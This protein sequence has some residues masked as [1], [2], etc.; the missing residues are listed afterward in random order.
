MQGLAGTI[1]LWRKS[2]WIH[3]RLYSFWCP[4]SQRQLLFFQIT[5]VEFIEQ[6]I[7]HY[8]EGFEYTKT[9]SQWQNLVKEYRSLLSFYIFCFV[10]VSIKGKE[11][12]CFCFIED[13]T[14]YSLSVFIFLADKI[15][16]VEYKLEVN[17]NN[18]LKDI[19]GCKH[20]CISQRNFQFCLV[21]IAY[22][23]NPQLLVS[24]ILISNNTF[25]AWK[26]NLDLWI[27]IN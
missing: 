24:C 26:G 7:L 1:K 21:C 8:Y 27:Q 22:Y 3:P 11:I 9:R 6:L 18:N 23:N 5:A 15:I 19:L 13:K 2:Y 25:F 16:F 17:T 20:W 4:F 14:S 10:S 12:P